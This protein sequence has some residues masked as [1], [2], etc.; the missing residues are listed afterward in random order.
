MPKVCFFKMFSRAP[1][2]VILCCLYPKLVNLRSHSKSNGCQ[3]GIRNQPTGA[4]RLKRQRPPEALRGS[5]VDDFR[6]LLWGRP[7]A[8][9][10]PVLSNYVEMC[11]QQHI[12]VMYI[13]VDQ[14]SG[15]LW[16][17]YISL[18]LYI[19]IYITDVYDCILYNEYISPKWSRVE[20]F[21]RPTG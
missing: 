8:H 16:S 13:T 12:S 18:S 2:W 11:G 7:R 3:N 4:K 14:R 20:V 17:S 1:F 19:Y 21:Q 15:E 5:I 9:P 6:T 10:L